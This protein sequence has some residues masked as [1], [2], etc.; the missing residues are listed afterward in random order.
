MPQVTLTTAP[1][2]GLFGPTPANAVA[3]LGRANT[4]ILASDN[5]ISCSPCYDGKNFASCA[6]NVC[7]ES[8]TVAA[9]ADAIAA[10]AR[11]GFP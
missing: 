6:R 4:R 10:V 1:L 2:V 3:P 9:V 11:K 8:I 7:L 5:R